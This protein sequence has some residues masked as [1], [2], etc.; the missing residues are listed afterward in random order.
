VPTV[1]RATRKLQQ[2]L[3]KK[4]LHAAEQERPDVKAARAV[5]FEAFRQ[6]TLEQLVFLDEFGA[7]SNMTRLYARGP[8]GQR[9]VCR[10]P[11]GH[12][13]MLSTIAAMNTSGILAAG[14][15]EHAVDED[16]FVAFVAQCLV[17]K[18]RPG[19]VVVL[20]NLPA[21]KSPQVDRLIKAAGCRVLRLPP[22]SP[23]LNPIENAISKI[24]TLLRKRGARSL[25]SVYYA[26]AEALDAITPNDAW[27]YMKKY[28]LA[29]TAA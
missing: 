5:W 21:H 12:W 26:I 23:D 3:K 18:L 19:Q 22:Y 8:R 17:P 1:F 4:S 28:R 20:D 25:V 27:G 2:P 9:I 10:T 6:V 11:H 14:T 15:F 7:S 16:T 29:A 24:K 13:K